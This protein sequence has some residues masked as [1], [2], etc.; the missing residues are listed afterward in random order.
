VQSIITLQ[1]ETLIHTQESASATVSSGHPLLEVSD[2]KKR[3][4]NGVWAN[5][6]ISLTADRPEILGILGPNGAGKTTLVRQITAEL[7]PTS[8][9]VELLGLDVVS[10]PT[11]AKSLLGVMPQEA[12][13]FDYLTVYQHLRIFA[14]LRG[15]APRESGPRANELIADLD[16]V[17][18]RNTPVKRLSGGLKRRVLVGTA[19]I[20]R[21]SVLVL[22]EPTTGLDPQTRRNLWSL[23]R[24]YKEQGTLVLLTTHSMEEAEAF[25]DRVGIMKDGR[26]LALDTVDNLRAQHNFEYKINYFPDGS[27]GNGVT[28]YG[29]D[30]QELVTKVRDLGHNQF[31]VGKTT[32][33]DVYLSLT[34]DD[35]RFDDGTR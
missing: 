23:L 10:N 34:E 7:I 15:L 33:E 6:G 29:S 12:D 20:A 3:Y 2:L 22:D 32:L 30:D 14:K 11:A 25:C 9:S 35:E 8:G 16:L 1:E 4:S 21:P 24:G 17:E 28:L 31:S 27:S 26:L 5:R 19:M 13:F 18:Y